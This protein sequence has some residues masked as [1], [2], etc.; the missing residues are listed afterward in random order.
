MMIDI[1]NMS[2]LIHQVLYL[3]D[4]R[5]CYTAVTVGIVLFSSVVL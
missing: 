4:D 5:S 1:S 2:K 3:Q